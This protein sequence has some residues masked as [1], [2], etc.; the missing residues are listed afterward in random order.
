MCA[1]F[2]TWASGLTGGASA[3]L[4]VA[5]L[6]DNDAVQKKMFGV[7][8]VLCMAV[9]VFLVWLREV[10]RREKLDERFAGLPKLKLAPDGSTPTSERCASERPQY[11]V[12]SFGR[13]NGQFPAFIAGSSTTP[14]SQRPNR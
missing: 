4:I 14:K 6:V 9:S 5:A 3:P 10:Q 8:A 7:F 1:V 11:R 13:L 2:S 12:T